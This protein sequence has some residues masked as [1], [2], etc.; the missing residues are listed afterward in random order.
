MP[1]FQRVW[2]LVNTVQVLFPAPSALTIGA[3][4]EL[5]RYDG[6]AFL[7]ANPGPLPPLSPVFRRNTRSGLHL[8]P[9]SFV[10]LSDQPRRGSVPRGIARFCRVPRVRRVIRVIRVI[11]VS[12]GE[13][14]PGWMALG[15][16]IDTRLR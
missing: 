4:S 6:L 7:Y 16:H 12:M 8:G 9:G 3:A 10:N 2:R 13:A 15:T 1:Y 14:P 5:V 11:R